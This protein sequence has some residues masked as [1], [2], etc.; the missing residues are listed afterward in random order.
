VIAVSAGVCLCLPRGGAHAADEPGQPLEIGGVT[1]DPDFALKQ[2]NDPVPTKLQYIFEP[3]YTF[4]NGSVRY[5]AQFEFQ[6]V[7]PYEGFFVPGAVVDGFRSVARLQLSGQ[8]QQ[9]ND[10][11]VS[12]LTDLTLTDSVVHD[13]GPFELGVGF[14]TVFPMA[15]DPALG[16]GKWQLGPTAQ[17]FFNT[18]P[19]LSVGALARFFWSVAGDSTRATLGYVTIRPLVELDLP[20]RIS[21]FTNALMNFTWAGGQSSVPINLGIGHD[22]NGHFIGQLQ[23]GYTVWGNGQG[24]IQGGVVLDFQP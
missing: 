7:A 4:P 5:V 9:M 1:V 2:V 16:Q 11:S 18:I 22:F 20:A 6:P 23:A 13:A 12:G 15:T 19:W 17:A 8:S 14:V 21:V 10:V 24:S 3:E